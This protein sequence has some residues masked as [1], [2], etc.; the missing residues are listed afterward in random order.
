MWETTPTGQTSPCACA[1]SSSSASSEPPPHAGDALLG[2]DLDAAQPREVDDD[3]VVAGREARDAVAAAPDG[4]DQVLLAGEA[5]RGDDV[6]VAVGRTI[7]AGRRSIMLFQ[8]A[9]ASS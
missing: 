1:A 4:D 3:P 5:E 9:R 7:S 8:T 2:I 6:V